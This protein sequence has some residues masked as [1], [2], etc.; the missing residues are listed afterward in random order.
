MAGGAAT[1][2]HGSGY[3]THAFKKTSVYR[4]AECQ[5]SSFPKMVGSELPRGWPPK[6][7]GETANT[8]LT[9]TTPVE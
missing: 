6:R 9:L 2:R 5:D 1:P 4:A 7:W 3:P 8:R